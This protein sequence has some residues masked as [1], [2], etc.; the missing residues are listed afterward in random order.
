[1]L[2]ALQA[3][4]GAESAVAHSANDDGE[5]AEETELLMQTTPPFP[6]VEPSTVA[7]E[8]PAVDEPEPEGQGEQEDNGRAAGVTGERGEGILYGH[9]QSFSDCLLLPLSQI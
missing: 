4:S 1:M 5:Q 3:H 6:T 7:G 9:E 2:S 8:P